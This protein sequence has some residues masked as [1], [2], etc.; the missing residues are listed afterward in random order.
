M[1]V[2]MMDEMDPARLAVEVLA[3]EHMRELRASYCWYVCRGDYQRIAE[4]YTP[5]GIFE[6]EQNGRRHALKGT[7]ALLEGLKE[8]IR[9]GEIFP[10]VHNHTIVIR[11]P[12]EAIG[13]CTMQAHTTTPDRP[14]FGGYYHD[15]FRR[16][17]GKW[18]FAERRF[19]RYWPDL[20]R[21]GLDMEGSPETGL[22]ARHD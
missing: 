15:F 4:L 13:S 1:E 19:F 21:S 11:S 5:D 10:N 7:Q 3:R 6:F 16:H 2:S 22:S 12:T 18:L 9:P 17:A 20:E 8:R 14:S